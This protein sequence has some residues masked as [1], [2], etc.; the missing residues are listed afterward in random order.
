[1]KNSAELMLR[2]EAKRKLRE[3]RLLRQNYKRDAAILIPLAET[4]GGTSLLFEVRSSKLKTQPGEVCFP[5]GRYECS[6]GNFAAT[7]RRETCEELGLL[8]ENVFVGGALDYLLT[9]WGVM[10]HPFLGE[11]RHI[12]KALLNHAEVEEIFCVPLSFLLT[13]EARTVR[14]R[15]FSESPDELPDEL[16]RRGVPGYVSGRRERPGYNLYFYEYDGH[17]IWG[18]TAEILHSFLERFA[19]ELRP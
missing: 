19:E 5:G 1:M 3:P 9:S 6:D 18:L 7:A 14:V 16:L 11:L 4:S 15:M 17:I 12:E 2:L 10:V 8:P 13:Y